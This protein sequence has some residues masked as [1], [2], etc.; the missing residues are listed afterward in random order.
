MLLINCRKNSGSTG[1][2]ILNPGCH[3]DQI[4]PLLSS[5]FK[6]RAVSWYILLATMVRSQRKFCNLDCLK[7]SFQQFFTIFYSKIYCL[8]SSKFCLLTLKKSSFSQCVFD[9]SKGIDISQNRNK[10]VHLK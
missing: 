6:F 2:N 4:I 3:C 5:H 10:H 7:Q 1:N 8:F 9:T